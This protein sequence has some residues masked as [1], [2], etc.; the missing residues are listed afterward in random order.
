M[1]SMLVFLQAGP[2]K[3]PA[4]LREASAST[5]GVTYRAVAQEAVRLTEKTREAHRWVWMYVEA[6][7]ALLCDSHLHCAEPGSGEPQIWR[8]GVGSDTTGAAHTPTPLSQ[9]R[10]TLRTAG[11]L[12]GVPPSCCGR[13]VAV[14]SGACST[15]RVWR[16]GTRRASSLRTWRWSVRRSPCPSCPT[17]HPPYVPRPSAVDHLIE[18]CCNVDLL[19][20]CHRRVC[21]VQ[22]TLAE[23]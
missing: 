2:A 7:H 15:I 21:G 1:Q 4:A 9:S 5:K 17:T 12:Q 19:S 22:C 16:S 23:R 3:C 6:R 11:T 18:T 14:W 20:H 10:P 13:R 8:A